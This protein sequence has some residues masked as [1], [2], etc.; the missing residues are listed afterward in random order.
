MPSDD[1]QITVVSAGEIAAL[2]MNGVQPLHYAYTPRGGRVVV[3]AACEAKPILERFIEARDRAE[4]MLD[5][6]A[7]V[8]S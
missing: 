2:L 6:K 5:A 4:S 3:F 8:R 7:K 1:V